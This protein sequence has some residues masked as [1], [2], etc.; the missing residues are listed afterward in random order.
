MSEAP[1]VV[2]IRT[3]GIPRFTLSRN[4]PSPEPNDSTELDGRSPSK[5]S[6]YGVSNYKELEDTDSDDFLTEAEEKNLQKKRMK[7]R[8]KCPVSGT[9]GET[10]GSVFGGTTD[11]IVQDVVEDSIAAVV[12]ARSE[13]RRVGKEC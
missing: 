12:A 3:K 6:R 4:E 13:E 8:R 11:G 1:F 7:K 5:R 10:P 9:S 2:R